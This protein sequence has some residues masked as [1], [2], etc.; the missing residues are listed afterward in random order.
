MEYGYISNIP[1]MTIN[2]SDFGSSNLPNL[3]TGQQILTVPID[4][5]DTIRQ[6]QQA[7]AETECKEAEERERARTTARHREL[8]EHVAKVEQRVSCP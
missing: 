7:A 3:P 2:S 4:I 8:L 5:N 1:W 6:A